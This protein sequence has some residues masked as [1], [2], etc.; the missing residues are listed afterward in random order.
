MNKSHISI[1]LFLISLLFI[2]PLS[3]FASGEE[4]VSLAPFQTF[5][6]EGQTVTEEIFAPYE[7]TMVNVWGTYCQPCIT[8]M[9]GLGVLAQ[10]YED[11]GVQ[12][13]GIV[14][15]VYSNDQ[16]VFMEKLATARS[17]IDYTQANYP[18]L[19]QSGDLVENYLKNVQVIPT[20]FFV[21]SEGTIVG[22]E[23]ISSRSENAWR[24]IIDKMIEDYVN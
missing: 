12:I 6:L 16:D 8:E 15:D 11:K 19:L 24:R 5:N 21:D 7:L 23:Y 1:R 3:L 9:P 10:E 14:V 18:H 4:E 20:T 2:L 17:I 13:V 22:R